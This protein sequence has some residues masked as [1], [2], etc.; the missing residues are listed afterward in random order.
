MAGRP[1]VLT[2]SIRAQLER[3]L[4]AGVKQEVAARGVGISTRSVQRFAAERRKP[5]PPPKTLDEDLDESLAVIFAEFGPR[6][7]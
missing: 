6:P 7:N 3:M 5:P 1:T 2:S 4:D